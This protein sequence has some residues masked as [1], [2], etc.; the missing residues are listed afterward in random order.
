MYQQVID[1]VIR[2]YFGA[3]TENRINSDTMNHVVRWA[4][5][6]CNA[7]VVVS[8]NLLQRQP[9]VHSKP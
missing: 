8:M 3:V 1:K 6:P 9:A 4:C 5:Q 7:N 2:K